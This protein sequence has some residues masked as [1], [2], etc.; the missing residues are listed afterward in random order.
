VDL[1]R[2]PGKQLAGQWPMVEGPYTEI[3]VMG[4]EIV[5]VSSEWLGWVPALMAIV[6]R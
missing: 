1:D 6:R 2:H 3:M 4:L 5:M